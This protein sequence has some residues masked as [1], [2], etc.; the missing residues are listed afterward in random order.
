MIKIKKNLYTIIGVIAVI[1]ILA[2]IFWGKQIP[3]MSIFN[4]LSNKNA[5][6]KPSAPA[7]DTSLSYAEA[8]QI[9]EGKRFQFSSNGVNN[10]IMNPSSAVSKMGT[11]VMLDNRIGKQVAIYLDGTAYNIEAYGFKI[12]TLTTSAQLPHTIKVDCDTGKNNGQ[13]ILGQ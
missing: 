12:V 8:L 5:P 3:G 11:K 7:P 4:S 1:V 2:I 6:A 9:Y 13:I 10:C